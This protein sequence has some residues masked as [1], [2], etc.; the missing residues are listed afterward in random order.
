MMDWAEQTEE[1]MK[2]WTETQKN[3]W[4][5]WLEM[6]QQGT[7]QTQ[8]A[9]LW[10]KTIETW[11][12]T[13][14]SSLDTQMEWINTW[15]EKLN[16]TEGVSDEMTEWTK[17]AQNMSKRWNETQQQLWQSWF[18]MVKKADPVKMAGA[19]GEESQKA[20]KAWQ[21]SAQKAMDSQMEW[22]SMWTTDKTKNDGK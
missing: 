13:V 10:Q 16:Q 1:M 14:K 20:F 2:T 19:W 6:V 18:D 7:G 8:A 22:A 11:E 12:N 17:Q 15:A 3:M 21:E 9:E 5:N 4:D